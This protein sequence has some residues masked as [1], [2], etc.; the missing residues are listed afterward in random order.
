MSMVRKLL[1]FMDN[2]AKDVIELKKDVKN[3][4]NDHKWLNYEDR[5]GN[6]EGIS[7]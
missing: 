4:I 3:L 2:M 7:E 5:N 1:D 6:K